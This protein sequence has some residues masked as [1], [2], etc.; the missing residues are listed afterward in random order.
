MYETYLPRRLGPAY[1]ES[2][3]RA[4]MDGLVGRFFDLGYSPKTVGEHLREWVD[5]ARAYEDD[6]AV[7]PSGVDSREVADY[8]DH[9]CERRRGGHAQVRRMLRVFLEDTP[10]C[11]RSSGR[12][13]RPKPALYEAFVPPYLDFVRRHRGRRTTHQLEYC[14]DRFFLRLA[15]SGVDS[16]CS[17]T[18]AHIRAF[19]WSLRGFKQATIATEA[20]AL[21]GFLRY[22]HQRELIEAKLVYAVEMPRLYR[23]RRPPTVLE[24][25]AVDRLL[26][27]VDRSTALGKRD[28]A[29]LTLA[30]RCGLRPSDIRALRFDHIHWRE[31]RIAFVQSKTQRVLEL[32][33]LADVQEA[34]VDYIRDG[35]PKCA[36]R[37]IFVRHD[38]WML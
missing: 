20:S 26:A 13:P 34:L 19:L 14:L 32:P 35:R 12:E 1:V 4:R 31:Q 24:E 2:R 15:E 33:L 22:L 29:M 8:V 28:Y 18:P 16:V 30:A 17:V 21:R 6:E 5:F 3:H 23:L 38:R 27:A 25:D 9:R 10:S 36:A 7:L 11:D 37:E